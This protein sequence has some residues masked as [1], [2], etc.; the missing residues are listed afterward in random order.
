MTSFHMAN[1]NPQ[2]YAPKFKGPRE[3]ASSTARS[4]FTLDNI[5]LLHFGKRVNF[6]NKLTTKE[7]LEEHLR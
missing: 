7:V 6:G 5:D 4:G 2:S 1:P 3:V